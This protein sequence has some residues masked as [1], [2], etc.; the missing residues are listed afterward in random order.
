M[1][2]YSADV[3]VILARK[4][5]ILRLPSDLIINDEYV[6]V[7]NADNIIEQRDV[8]LGISNWQYS[9]ILSGINKTDKIISSVGLT[10]V[11]VGVFAQD[12]DSL[13]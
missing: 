12:N 8:A 6:L 5:N 13:D 2:G 7:L 1:A 10:G 11:K 4:E 9:E 3:E